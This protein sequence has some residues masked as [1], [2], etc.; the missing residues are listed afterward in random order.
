[1]HGR[2]LAMLCIMITASYQRQ[3]ALRG[4]QH[5]QTAQLCTKPA[6]PPTATPSQAA[7]KPH[8]PARAP[9]ARLID[10]SRPCP[11]ES[12]SSS[13]PAV[14]AG[15]DTAASPVASMPA[16]EEQQA[17][18]AVQV[19]AQLGRQQQPGMALVASPAESMPTSHGH[20]WGG[21][22]PTQCQASKTAHGGKT[23]G[24]R[25][26]VTTVG[27]QAQ[28]EAHSLPAVTAHKMHQIRKRERSKLEQP[29]NFQN[30]AAIHSLPAVVAGGRE[31]AMRTH[32]SPPSDIPS[33]SN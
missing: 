20:R 5:N 16:N 10:P 21:V 9:A 2:Q 19:S 26:Q 11:P 29:A 27:V 6:C 14:E 1:M 18:G 12:A 33:T 25:Q 30:P 28:S 32:S 4:W 17:S 3:A 13:S 31:D 24:T 7:C 15:P 8:L 22:R 23:A